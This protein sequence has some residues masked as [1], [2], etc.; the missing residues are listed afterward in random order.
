MGAAADGRR[1]KR[2]GVEWPTVLLAI[3]IYGGFLALTWFHAFLPIW[4]FAPACAWLVAWHSSLQH[5]IIHGHPTRS[6]RINRMIGNIPLSLWMPYKTYRL[7]HLQHHCDEQLTDP[8]DDPEPRY[9]TA[10]DWASLGPIGRRMLKLQK[11]LLG[12]LVVGP[13]WA[14]GFFLADEA[15][16]LRRRDPVAL[17]AWAEHLVGVAVVVFW[18]MA[19][20]G[21]SLGAYVVTV[22]YPAI[23]LL[24]IR[25]FA[26]HKA[27]EGVAERTAIVENSWILGPLFLFNN[28]HA[29]HHERP[30]MPWYEIPAWYAAN[31]GRLI[32]ETGG[33]VYDGYFDV[34]RRFMF[35]DH[36]S[37]VHPG[38]GSTD[39]LDDYDS[40]SMTEA[41]SPGS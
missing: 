2:R 29:V 26:E 41:V 14:V 10:E 36:D 7:A 8:L 15:V 39:V 35:S 21:L 27:A 3:L 16:K 11:T 1:T 34:A 33:H 37:V 30:S 5:E 31:R 19:V 17:R 24:L 32:L 25:S 9:V 18:L 20:C 6:R 28:L 38:S 12:R 4:V 13:I 40:S 23:S 22:V